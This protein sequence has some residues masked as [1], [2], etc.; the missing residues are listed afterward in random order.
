M[1]TLV[2]VL[3]T[4]FPVPPR[5]MER[6]TPGHDQRNPKKG[7]DLENKL[8]FYLYLPS[9]WLFTWCSS[10]AG[11]VRDIF[12]FTSISP[13]SWA[14]CSHC[15]CFSKEDTQAQRSPTAHL[16]SHRVCPASYSHAGA[17]GLFCF[18]SK[19]Y[20][21]CTGLLIGLPHFPLTHLLWLPCFLFSLFIKKKWH[22]LPFPVLPSWSFWHMRMIM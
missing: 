19:R 21:C 8:A 9:A 22:S 13:K 10:T 18:I 17:W 16:V 4:H 15:M 5:H 14:R 12:S 1:S 20:V 7:L 11:H 6:E 3:H 2:T